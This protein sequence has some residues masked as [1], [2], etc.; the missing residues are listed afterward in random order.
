MTAFI[1]KLVV[2]PES[3]K[4]LEDLQIELRELTH[5]QEP[6]C[7]VYELFRSVNDS[8]IYYCI[9]SFKDQTAFDHHMTIDFHDRLVPPILECLGS[10]MELTMCEAVGPGKAGNSA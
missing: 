5:A 9:A 7:Y 10:D 6:D 2:K 3:A 4:E 1:A 8:N